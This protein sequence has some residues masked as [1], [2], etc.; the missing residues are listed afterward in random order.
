MVFVVGVAIAVVDVVVVVVDVV[1][2][3]A[4]VVI[5]VV[6]VVVIFS[7][8]VTLFLVSLHDSVKNTEI[9]FTFKYIYTL[10]RTYLATPPIYSKK[11]KKYHMILNS[12]E[13][14]KRHH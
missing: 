6:A 9:F 12:I 3:A 10:L 14:L 2:V 13:L 4:T 1:V 5:I 11:K 8:F 7:L